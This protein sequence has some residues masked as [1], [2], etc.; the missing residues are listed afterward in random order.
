MSNAQTQPAGRAPNDAFIRFRDRFLSGF[1]FW[2]GI[3][4]ILFG[5]GVGFFYYPEWKVLGFGGGVTLI[6]W[7]A[8][9]RCGRYGSL[10]KN[11]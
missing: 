7:A 8:M 11:G 10:S 2:G 5:I 3:L 4:Q 1:F 9:G 6:G